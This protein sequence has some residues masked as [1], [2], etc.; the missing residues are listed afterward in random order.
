ML[1][2]YKPDKYFALIQL[3][4]NAPKNY[5]IHVAEERQA[6]DLVYTGFCK[7]NVNKVSFNTDNL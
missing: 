5:Y 4:D 2:Y 6:K 1:S 3:K 7:G